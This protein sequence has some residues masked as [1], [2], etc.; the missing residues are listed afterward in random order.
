MGTVRFRIV[1]VVV[2]SVALLSCG[3]RFDP[4]SPDKGPREVEGQVSVPKKATGKPPAREILL[5]EMC[6]NAAADRP[7]VKPIIVRHVVWEDSDEA[8]VRPIESRSA[9]QFSILGWDGR[10]VGLFTAA[11]AADTNGQGTVATGSYAGGSPCQPKGSGAK[12]VSFDQECVDSLAHCGLAVA[13]LEPSAGYGAK[14]YEEDPKAA[15]FHLS[16]ACAVDGKLVVD[17]DSDGKTEAFELSDFIDAFRGP[18]EEVI[19]V[20]KPKK[21]CKPKFA[22]RGVVPKG[23]PRDWLGL[24]I[25]GVLDLDGDGRPEIVAGYNYPDRRTWAVYTAQAS[26]GRLDLVGEGIPWKR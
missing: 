8:V 22:A 9:R 19:S 16:G 1:F 24:D 6:P 10:R 11:G 20:D 4:K 15:T 21:S 3:P 26:S 12:D 5:G 14:P 23:D 2:G 17:I 18:S 13:L 25:L 7:A